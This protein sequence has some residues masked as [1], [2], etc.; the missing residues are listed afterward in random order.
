MMVVCIELDVVWTVL[1]FRAKWGQ[2]VKGQGHYQAK[3]DRKG[4]VM[5]QQ[6]LI[7]FCPVLLFCN[8]YL[9]I[10]LLLHLLQL[11]SDAL[12]L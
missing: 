1:Q 12:L 6:L 2:K 4:G 3:Y 11:L 10:I 7:E 8:L 5:Q 9:D